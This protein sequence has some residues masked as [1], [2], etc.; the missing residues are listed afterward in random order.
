MIT[1]DFHVHSDFSSDSDTPMEA[2]IERAIALGMKKICFT[3]HMDYGF[4]ACYKL[5]FVFDPDPYFRKLEL[6]KAAYQDRIE[7][8]QGVELGLKPDII[9]K[10]SAL[11]RD[12]PFD[13]VIASSHLVDNTDP[14]YPEFWQNRTTEEAINRYF[15]TVAENIALFSDFDTYGHLDYV[16]RY[17]PAGLSGY[18]YEI[19]KEGIDSALKA[20]VH[21]GKCLEVNTAGYKFGFGAPN[22]SA[23]IIKKYFELGGKG[24]TI[25]S[26]GHKPEHFAY[27]FPELENLLSSLGITEYYSFKHRKGIIMRLDAPQCGK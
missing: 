18:T 11:V 5:P 16:M 6:V 14:Y 4:P 3:D 27:A 17:C 9:D 15:S 8:L 22:P 26:D 10:A 7:V 12:Y 1:A 20:I 13:F 24:I 21:A 19:Y 25:G 2:M 23:A